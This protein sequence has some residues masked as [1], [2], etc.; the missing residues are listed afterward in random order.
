MKCARLVINVA[1]AIFLVIKV[2]ASKQGKA[3]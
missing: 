2:R 3:S 1:I